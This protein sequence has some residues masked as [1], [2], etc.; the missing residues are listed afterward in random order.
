MEVYA[1]MITGTLLS[2]L[3]SHIFQGEN[4]SNALFWCFFTEQSSG[5]TRAVTE[6]MPP[7]MSLGKKSQD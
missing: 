5:Y 7:C 6:L 4:H 3:T 1:A 2:H